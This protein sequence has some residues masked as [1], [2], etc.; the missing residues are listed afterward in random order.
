LVTI[1]FHCMGKNNIETLITLKIIFFYVQ[2]KK[3]GFV[4]KVS[5][6]FLSELSI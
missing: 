4:T 5:K 2:Q 6:L 1:G 3:E